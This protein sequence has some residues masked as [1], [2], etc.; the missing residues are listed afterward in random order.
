MYKLQTSNGIHKAYRAATDLLVM[1]PPAGH[2]YGRG[3]LHCFI[4][5]TTVCTK[6]SRK[7]NFI[8]ERES[9]RQNKC[10]KAFIGVYNRI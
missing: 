4:C 8:V 6:C 2:G 3:I 5:Q 10:E 7:T 1:K 9:K